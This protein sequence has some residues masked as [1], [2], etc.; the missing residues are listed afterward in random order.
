MHSRDSNRLS[1]SSQTASSVRFSPLTPAFGARVSG[2]DLS[3]TLSECVKAE[4]NQALS[5][6]QILLF[7][8]Q[9]LSEDQQV[10]FAQNF[11]SC[12]VPM[13]SQHYPSLNPLSH[14]ISNVDRDG[15]PTG[16]HP[17]PDSRYWHSDGSWLPQPYKATVLHAIEV[18]QGEGDT[19]FANMYQ[20][21]EDLD[22]PMKNRLGQLTA[23][24]HVKL[25]RAA[26]YY[27]LPWQWWQT[28]AGDESLKRR[29]AWWIKAIRRRRH[30]GITLHPVV[31]MHS[32]TGRPLL[33][34][35]D[36]AWRITGHFWPKGVRL[37]KEINNL[38]FRP[39]AVYSHSWATGDLL[40][41]EN[42]SILHRVTAYSL[43]DRVRIMRRCVVLD[44]A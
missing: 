24:H 15:H 4:L 25:T 20:V 16:L 41:W 9:R 42:E 3:A 32:E 31:R 27:R 37:M 21:Y 34:I 44:Q 26:R 2:V 23:E 1:N 35:G 28:G 18:P 33:F 43:P 40:I 6:Y 17:D 10:R 22:Q 12:R 30:D 38:A 29:L 8:D 39:E 14:Y 19:Q 5:Q 36:H 13:Q 7:R 11:G